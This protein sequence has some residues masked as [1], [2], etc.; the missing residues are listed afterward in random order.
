MSSPA[1]PALVAPSQQEVATEERTVAPSHLKKAGMIGSQED[2][3][4]TLPSAPM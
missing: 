3:D 4:R 1:P 2:G